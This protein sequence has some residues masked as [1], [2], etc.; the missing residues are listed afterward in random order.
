[1]GKSS[2]RPS[3]LELWGGTDGTVN[4]VGDRY[5]DQ[6]ALTGHDHRIEDLDRFADL[7]ISALRYPV[8][9][10]RVAPDGLDSADWSWTDERLGRLRALGI[11][12]IVGLVHHGSGPPHTSLQDPSF[13]EGL[14]AFA[15][16]VAERY[17]WVTHYTPVNEPLTT[18]RFSGL[19]GHWYPH[20]R[21][22]A[23]FVRMVLVQCRAIALAMGAIRAVRPDAV[24]VQTDDLGTIFSTPALRYQAGHENERRWLAYDLLAGRV[25]GEHP[26]WP[27]LMQ[28]GVGEEE[29]LAFADRPCPPDIIGINHYLSS[30]RYLDEHIARYP[31]EPAGGNGR[32]RYVDV[33][34]ARLR[35]EGHGGIAPLLRAAW[36]RYGLPIAVT[37][38]HNGCT[39]EE[40]MRW[41]VEVWRAAEEARG[42]GIDVRAV[43]AWSLL[44]VH[45]WDALVTGEGSYEAGVFDVRC[46]PPRPTAMVP[47]L[48]SLAA[49]QTPSHPLLQVPGW[50]RRDVRFGHGVALGDGGSVEAVDP[51]AP[52]M[53][54]YLGRPLLIAGTGTLGQATARLCELR[55][56]PYR[57]LGRREMDIAD[58]V[59][60]EVAVADF[61]PW[62]LINAAGYVRVDDAESDVA[63]CFRENTDGARVLAEATAA[64]GIPYVTFSSDLVFDGAKGDPY[65]ESDRPA[66]LGAYGA[67][68]RH[69][70]EAVLSAHPGALVI[71]TS[72]FFGPW[73]DYNFVTIALHALAAGHEL[74]AASD[75]FVSPTYVP[76]LVNATLDLLIDGETGIRHLANDGTVTWAELAR[77]AAETT[78]V[79]AGGVRPVPAA[80]LEQIAVRPA[81]SVLGTERG[82]ILSPLED[83]LASY[84]KAIR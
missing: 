79:P 13:A 83:A 81:Y 6:I 40:Q 82:Q 43:T 76:D 34:A 11:Q 80:E 24:L 69:A 58:P 46:S 59:S 30:D 5:I 65:I 14:A 17:P 41:F 60:V 15:R 22:A 71:R 51:E 73:D 67:S 18:A 37:E 12:P 9:W 1:M 10:E 35:T 2:V 20:A 63:R 31:G 21:D 29:I 64:A 56:I 42:E 66:P 54:T 62:A 57:L 84:V 78:G 8:L 47:V 48:Q 28:I 7:G 77:L 19:Y 38:A 75:Q 23:T 70:E 53:A 27:W 52:E 36:G 50:W 26:L 55:G 16:A 33:P 39:R 49:G 32:H 44:G 3:R 74:R 45:G 61:R 68:K 25:D 4:R 72:A